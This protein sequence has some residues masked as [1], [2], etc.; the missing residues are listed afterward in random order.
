M[1]HKCLLEENTV[2]HQ[3]LIPWP[4]PEQDIILIWHEHGKQNCPALCK[5]SV[6]PMTGVDCPTWALTRG[7][8]P[9]VEAPDAKMVGMSSGVQLPLSIQHFRDA[10]NACRAWTA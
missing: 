5:Y 7:E 2:P 1:P 6:A 4:R 10:A 8:S 3:A 9:V